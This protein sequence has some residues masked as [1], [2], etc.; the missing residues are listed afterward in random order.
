VKRRPNFHPEMLRDVV[1][2]K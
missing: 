1:L 2:G